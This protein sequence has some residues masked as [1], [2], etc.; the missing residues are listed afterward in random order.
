MTGSARLDRRGFLGRTALLG[1]LA[2][3]PGLLSACTRTQVGSGAPEDDGALL[4]KLRK[5]GFVRVGFA[6][7]AP[8]GFQDGAEPA[9]EAPTLHREVF[10]ALGVRELRPTLTEFGALIPGLL[11]DRFDVVSA[12]MSITPERCAKVI[13]SEPEFVSPTALMVR[14]GNPKGLS[15]LASCAARS[16]TV[17][18][19]MAAVEAS[20][21]KAAGVPDGSV[22]TLAKQQDGLDALLAGRIDA[23]ALTAISL[24]WLART[25]RDAAVEVTEAFV[26]VVDGERQLGAGGAVFR[27][28]ATGLRDAF[29]K[30]LLGITGSPDRFVDLLGRYG[31]TAREVP[32]RSLRTADL[33]AG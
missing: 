15:D 16:V 23:F 24:R 10:T 21:A 22:K 20:F 29:N 27:P 3:S 19:L 7:E 25:N 28:G 32:P 31:F 6:G 33:C 12:G 1:G 9:G 14:K 26:P 18:V 11:A 4:A 13:F 17:G 2:L 8:Y 5:Q 30:E